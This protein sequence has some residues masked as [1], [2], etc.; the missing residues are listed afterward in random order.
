MQAKEIKGKLKGVF[1]EEQAEVLA[2]VI[3]EAYED[4]VRARDFNELKAIVKEL[5]Q[6][7][8]DSE[9][10][11][12]RIETVIE[13]LAQAQKRTEARVE[14]LAQAQKRTQEEVTRLDR[15]V[16]ELAQ[17]QKRTEARVEELAQAQKRTQEE[18]TRLD[19]A[20]QE[21]AKAQKRTEEELLRF[22]R[23]FDMKLGALGARW[24]YDSEATFR[25]AVE[26]ILKDSGFQV[27]HYQDYDQEGAVF[28]RPDQVELDLIIKDSRVLVAEIKS[29]VNRADLAAFERKVAFYQGRTGR[30][31]EEKVM[32]S[33]FVDPRGTERLAEKLGIRLITAPEE[34]D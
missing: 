23:H 20:V 13:E 29:S 34:L 21:L 14:E 3:A 7:Q 16:Q 18:V 22:G 15:A 10:R 32:I 5:A 31:V 9:K 4:L 25:E 33:P 8:R 11:L 17:A 1:Q 28:G 6:A 27:E 19:R 12:T 26:Y 2:A 30:Q 24:G